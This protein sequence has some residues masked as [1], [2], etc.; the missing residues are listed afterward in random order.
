LDARK[1]SY[2]EGVTPFMVLAATF[3]ALLNRYTRQEDLVL[4]TLSPAGRKRSETE[5]MLGYFL[6]PVA[7]RFDLTGNPAFRDLLRQTQKLTLEAISND[8]IPL[9]QVAHEVGATAPLFTAA[10]SLQPP[11]RKL[12]LEWSVTSMDVDSGGS[13][14]NLYLVFIDRPGSMIGRVQYNP[15]MFEEMTINRMLQDFQSL[16][17]TVCARPDKPLNELNLPSGPDRSQHGA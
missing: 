4:G 9:E 3:A 14:W 7:L 2:R 10:V 8:D 13:P 11:T 16:L 15:D 6:N 1:L 12:D 5:G 17:E